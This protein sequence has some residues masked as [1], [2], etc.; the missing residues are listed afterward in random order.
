ML[1]LLSFSISV[2]QAVTSSKSFTK[3]SAGQFVWMSVFQPFG[4][5][6]CP[7]LCHFVYGSFTLHVPIPLA[8][9]M[10]SWHFWFALWSERYFFPTFPG[11]GWDLVQIFLFNVWQYVPSHNLTFISCNPAQVITT[12]AIHNACSW[13]W[14]MH[15]AQSGFKGDRQQH[16]HQR[17][18]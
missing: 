8:L 1:T 3:L 17:I 16:N 10:D 14:W 6:T 7:P 4:D 15:L 13:L 11:G 9:V 12:S 2:R 5:Q 18:I